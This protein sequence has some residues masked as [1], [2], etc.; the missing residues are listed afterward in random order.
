MD[1]ATLGPSLIQPPF[2]GLSDQGPGMV[3]NGEWVLG[4]SG[5]GRPSH[6][7]GPA[8]PPLRILARVNRCGFTTPPLSRW[9][10][11]A[12]GGGLGA[13]NPAPTPLLQEHPLRP[14]P[15]IPVD[16]RSFRD[17]QMGRFQTLY[18]LRVQLAE[19][20]VFIK[21]SPPPLIR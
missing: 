11:D 3:G 13:P 7:A 1:F 20:G 10:G 5:G 19:S 9:G 4:G 21:Q 2:I 18:V 17:R 8:P 15:V 14:P 6:P 16:P 12:G